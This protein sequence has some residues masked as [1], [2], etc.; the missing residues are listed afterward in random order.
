MDFLLA[1][2]EKH[3]KIKVEQDYRI[4]RNRIVNRIGD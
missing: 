4:E 3:G 1:L 2:G